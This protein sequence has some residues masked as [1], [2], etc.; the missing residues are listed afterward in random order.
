M[1]TKNFIGIT[2]IISLLLAV[3]IH[4]REYS[5]RDQVSVWYVIAWQLCIWLT[6]V[7]GFW[8]LREVRK[9]TLLQ[10][11]G[12]WIG[13]LTGLLW[14]VCHFGWFFMISSNFSPYLDYP[15]SRFGV[16]R[17]FFIFWTLIDFGLLWFVI[18]KLWTEKES[19]AEQDNP[20]LLE[21]T[22][23][24]KSYFF[25]PHQIHSLTAENYYTKLSTTS[26]IFVMR[27]P[28]K[29]FHDILPSPMFQKIHRSTIVNVEYVS[30]LVG[31]MSQGLELVLK[32][33][34]KHKVSRSFSKK[35]QQ[36]FKER[37]H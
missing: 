10:K 30:E 36:F 22:R 26:G 34:T 24:G 9:R 27:K 33:Q 25:E 2:I 18:D 20:I 21:L 13:F 23:G 14:I 29:E 31:N 28:L 35:I 11:Y 17:Y 6:W 15:E 4:W 16:Y 3:L 5:S 1:K 8:A 7:L 19:K 32:D 12:K 37:T